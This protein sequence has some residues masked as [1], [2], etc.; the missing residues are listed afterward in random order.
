MLYTISS[1]QLNSHSMSTILRQICL[2][3]LFGI[4]ARP[5]FAQQVT[6]VLSS[7]LPPYVEAFQ[8]FQNAY[9]SPIHQID[10]KNGPQ[11]IPSGTQIIVALGGKAALQ[12]YR[13]NATMIYALAPGL[14]LGN[15]TNYQAVIKVAMVPSAQDLLARLKKIQPK[16]RKLGVFWSASAQKSYINTLEQAAQEWD[17]EIISEQALQTDDLPNGLRWMLRKGIDGIW[18]PPDPVLIT[19][20]SFSMFREFSRANDIPLYVPSNG[21]LDKGAVASISC[22]FDEVGRTAGDIARRLIE[23]AK[24]TGVV[25]PSQIMLWVNQQ[26]ATKAGLT[27]DQIAIQE[28]GGEVK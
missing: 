4:F 26:A 20:R 1:H 5:A 14:D 12:N 22:R 8:A 9:G 25:Y 10:L 13:S 6:V 19:P 2:S 28:M 18:L 24:I 11:D 15:E 23:G 17:V 16:L 27:I 3:L 7:D 21:L